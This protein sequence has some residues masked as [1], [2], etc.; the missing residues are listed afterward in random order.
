MLTD[1]PGSVYV[2]EARAEFRK[3]Q[4][5]LKTEGKPDSL[6]TKEELLL[7]GKELNP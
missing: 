1:Y 4:E 5:S 7:E 6:K 2:V 3:M